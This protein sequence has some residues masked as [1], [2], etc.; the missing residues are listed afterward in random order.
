MRS[1]ASAPCARPSRASPGR[2]CSSRVAARPASRSTPSPRLARSAPARS[3]TSTTRRREQR[4]RRSS[5]QR[6]CARNTGRVSAWAGSRSPSMRPRGKRGSASASRARTP[7]A[8]APASES[9]SPM[10]RC[11][12]WTCTRAVSASSPA[13]PTRVATSPRP[14]R[15][16]RVAPSPSQPS[17]PRSS[18]GS[19]PPRRGWNRQRSWFSEGSYSCG[20]LP[21]RRRKSRP[22]I[23][24]G[25]LGRKLDRA[26]TAPYEKVARGR[27]LEAFPLQEHRLRAALT[28]HHA[29]GLPL[30]DLGLRVDARSRPI[31]EAVSNHLRQVAHELVVVVELI[32]LDTDDRA[33]VGDA[34]EQIAALRVQE[35]RD[36]L[37]HGVRHALVVLPILLE[38][39]AQR[40]LELQRL[41]LAALDQLLGAAVAAEVL[42]EEEVLDRLAEGPV[43]GDPLVELE[44]GVHDLLDDVLDL[45]VEGEA[46]VLPRV[47]PRGGIERGVVVELLHHL[48]ERHAMFGAEV[49]TEAFVQLG[50]D[51]RERLQ[52]PGSGLVAGARAHRIADPRP[53]FER[54]PAARCLLDP[55]RLHVDVLLH[56]ARQLGPVGGQQPAQVA[57]EDVEL[58]ELHVGEG[59]HLGQKRVEPN[60]VRELA[61]EVLL[62]LLAERLEALDHG[63]EYGVKAILRRLGIEVDLGEAVHV[64]R[65]VDWELEKAPLDFVQ[66]IRIGR[67]REE[68][69][70]VVRL[71]SG[72]DL[73]GLVRE[74]EHHGALLLGVRAIKPRERLH[75]A[76]AAELLVHVHRMQERLVEAG[77][78]LV[79]DDEEPILGP[80]ERLRR[81]GLR[82]AVHA[83]L[84]VGLPAVLHRA[85]ERHKRLERIPAFGEVL[86]H[87]QLVA[88]RVQARARHDHR[89]SLA[90]DVALGTGCEVLDAD[91][92][93]LADGVRVQLD[94]GF[95]QI[96]GLLLTSSLTSIL[97]VTAAETWAVLSCFMRFAGLANLGNERVNPRRLAAQERGDCVLLVRRWK[98]RNYPPKRIRIEPKPCGTH[99]TM[100][101]PDV[102]MIE[103]ESHE[104]CQT[105]A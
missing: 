100:D 53:A 26:R 1:T 76:D 85:G 24:A 57:R 20:F 77:L 31:A 49:E 46:Y 45:L 78:E 47:D 22:D 75:G 68:R 2:A 13:G 48:S 11:P 52:L 17:R 89:L 99:C 97:P 71:E 62:L 87:R 80:L 54:D 10:S 73:V 101:S 103:A 51:A 35:R 21:P 55:V 5:V 65:G 90:A 95:Q 72:P 86:V 102:T 61:A 43:V 84:S 3:S 66:E 32:A 98:R 58:L 82:K 12:C 33:V 94:E 34:N 18:I 14:W 39:P 41:R 104:A 42:V 36:G 40:G 15:S 30:H 69:R 88:H 29:R 91:L 92:H 9:T 59:Q 63:R 23:L 60:V 74:V 70:L 93:L 8:S 96:F 7:T 44:I 64:R 27:R 67:F 25:A 37:E 19:T 50:D 6:S 83:R 16:P 81:L 28:G 79:G 38:A 105:G 56:L 4:L